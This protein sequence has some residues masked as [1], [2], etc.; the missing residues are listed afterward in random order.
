[1]DT[2]VDSAQLAPLDTNDDHSVELLGVGHYL[3]ATIEGGRNVNLRE[4][5]VSDNHSVYTYCIH[6][7]RYTGHAHCMHVGQVEI[8]AVTHVV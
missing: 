8:I 3:V 1:M 4:G 7:W 2:T 5:E 6:Q